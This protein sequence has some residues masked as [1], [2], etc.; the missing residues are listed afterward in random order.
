MTAAPVF[1]LSSA[2]PPVATELSVT[3]R[4][5]PAATQAA[6]VDELKRLSPECAAP[7]SIA[8]SF[9]GILRGRD[10]ARLDGWIDW[11]RASGLHRLRQFAVTPKNDIAAVRNATVEPWSDGQ[12]EGQ[13]N[14]LK[15]LKRA[16]YGR[17]GIALLR[18]RM[19][20]LRLD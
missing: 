14:K 8:M 11:A 12:T 9:R 17:A 19:T 6:T 1:P 5:A 20:P 10:T 4:N 13:I 2:S 16:M 15:I 7:C 3:P 18:A